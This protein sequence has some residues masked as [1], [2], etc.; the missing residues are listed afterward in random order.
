MRTELVHIKAAQIALGG[1]NLF[2]LK[3]FT[4]TDLPLGRDPLALTAVQ[5]LCACWV[6]S[7]FTSTAERENLTSTAAMTTRSR[8]RFE[9]RN[10]VASFSTVGTKERWI[11]P[12][13]LVKPPHARRT[14][15][16]SR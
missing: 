1:R 4:R 11:M 13:C 12:Q 14:G 5:A 8:Q 6:R 15:W 3:I 9:S 2:E 7:V 16:A 10:H